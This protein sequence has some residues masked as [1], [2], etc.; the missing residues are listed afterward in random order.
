VFV[1]CVCSVHFSEV[2]GSDGALLRLSGYPPW[3]TPHFRRSS[4]A[5]YDLVM[6][7]ALPRPFLFPISYERGEADLRTRSSRSGQLDDRYGL[8]GPRCRN[9]CRFSGFIGPA[10]LFVFMSSG[11][12][13]ERLFRPGTV[14]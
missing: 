1:I 14:P 6:K 3:I 12:F 9:L 4:P 2:T 11:L 10:F 7:V 5:G 8:A 13:S